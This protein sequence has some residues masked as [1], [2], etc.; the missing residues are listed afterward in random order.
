MP[1]LLHHISARY[2]PAGPDR[3][4]RARFWGLPEARWAKK[5]KYEYCYQFSNS[6]MAPKIG[7][8]GQKCIDFRPSELRLGPKQG[9][10]AVSDR[11]IAATNLVTVLIF[12]IFCPLPLV[13]GQNGPLEPYG[14]SIFDYPLLASPKMDPSQN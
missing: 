14:R 6:K 13:P 12:A 2:P 8:S 10:F 7:A 9:D 1:R 11:E 5:A 3:A 4:I